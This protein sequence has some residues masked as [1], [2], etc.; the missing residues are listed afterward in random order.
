[1]ELSL[2][3][4]EIS[5]EIVFSVMA[6]EIGPKKSFQT[7][8][9]CRHTY[10]HFGNVFIRSCDQQHM[11]LDTLFVELSL[12][13]TEISTGIVFSVMT[14]VIGPENYTGPNFCNV[15]IFRSPQR[16]PVNSQKSVVEDLGGGGGA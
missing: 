12:I 16:I 11:G 1:M 2:I 7:E 6:V 8:K 9:N 4:T 13:L 15:N 10:N 14:V 5:T 3:L